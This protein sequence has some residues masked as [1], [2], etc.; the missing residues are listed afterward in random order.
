[1]H[2]LEMQ[3]RAAVLRRNP[4]HKTLTRPAALY[5]SVKYCLGRTS[6][7]S[8]RFEPKLNRLRQSAEDYYYATFQVIQ[9]RGFRFIVLTHTHPHTYP[10]TYTHRDEVI[11]ISALPYYVVGELTGYNRGVFTLN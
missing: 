9:I 10:H 11:A 4:N 2:P 3:I 7:T 1:M 5:L 8:F 6:W